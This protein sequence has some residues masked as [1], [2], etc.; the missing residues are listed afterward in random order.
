MLKMSL[1]FFSCCSSRWSA[2]GNEAI[3]NQVLV[4]YHETMQRSQMTD[5][6]ARAFYPILPLAVIGRSA[7]AEPKCKPRDALWYNW[8][9]A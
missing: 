3:L 9:D 5:Y 6:F 1:L 4:I 7:S 2:G 8:K